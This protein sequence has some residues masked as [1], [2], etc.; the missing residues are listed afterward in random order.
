MS[1]APWNILIFK[2]GSLIDSTQTGCSVNDLFKQPIGAVAIRKE[3]SDSY[4]SYVKERS[5]G[6]TSEDWQILQSGKP[7]DKLLIPDHMK[8]M[9][10]LLP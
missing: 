1:D 7:L 4:S 3:S 10:L 9:L 6:H 2:D 5:V 8:A